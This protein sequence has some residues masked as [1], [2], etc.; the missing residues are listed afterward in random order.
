MKLKREEFEAEAQLKAL[1]VQAGTNRGT[2]IP[3]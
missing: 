2:E 1:E 3:S